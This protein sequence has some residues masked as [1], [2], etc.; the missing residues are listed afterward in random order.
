M[1]RRLAYVVAAAACLVLAAPA[2]PALASA[3]GAPSTAEAAEP[4]EST[5]S[6][7]T[8]DAAEA[9]GRD[10]RSDRSA[11]RQ[12]RQALAALTSAG[13]VSAIAEIRDRDGV[14]RGASGVS[15]LATGAPVRGDGRFR[16]GS[17]TKVFVATTVLQLVGEHRIGLDDAVEKHLPGLVPN[18]AN[19]TVRQLL[20]HTSGLWDPTN[21]SGGIFPELFDPAV[22]RAWFA[23]GG[24]QRTVTARQLVAASAAHAPYFVPG[25]EWRYSNTNYALLG[26]LIEK[27]TGH[28]YGQEITRRVLRPLGM[29][30]SSFPGSASA[31]PGPHAHGYWTIV[32]EAGPV[33]KTYVDVTE[34]N[35]TW[36]GAAGALISSTD[37]LVRFE[38]ALLRGQLL[39]AWLMREMT[40]AVPTEPGGHQLD[41]GLGLARYQLSCGPVLGHNGGIFGYDTQ[42]WGTADRQVALS[43]TGRGDEKDEAAQITAMRA[44]L[45]TAFCGG[46]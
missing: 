28:E 14:W 21:E 35:P 38:R 11:A 42:L 46:R 19:V 25:A 36:A 29:D 27:A 3:A 43:Y 12:R 13:A 26:L 15:D 34:H 41:Y 39:P 23:D 6:A 1:K 8:A 10:G 45:E 2:A 18:G 22:F 40:A 31:I 20:N 30:D 37:D 7:E 17:V 24:L 16:A 9:E 5:E 44:F 33:R 32:D 4:T